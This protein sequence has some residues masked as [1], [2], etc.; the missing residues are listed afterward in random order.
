[1]TGCGAMRVLVEARQTRPGLPALPR[2]GGG[3]LG[4]A[5]G[6]RRRVKARGRGLGLVDV[7]DDKR[8]INHAETQRLETSVAAVCV[9]IPL[10]CLRI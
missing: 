10:L 6:M 5:D 8:R 2:R 4:R 7:T 3:S 1:M 9:H